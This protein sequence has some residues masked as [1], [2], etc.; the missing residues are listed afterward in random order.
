M[1]ITDADKTTKR[2]YRWRTVTEAGIVK[3]FAID[4][5]DGSALLIH[6]AGGTSFD[7][8]VKHMTELVDAANNYKRLREVERVLIEAD[9]KRRSTN[10][11]HSKSMHKANGFDVAMALIRANRE[12]SR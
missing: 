10:V 12:E 6:Q 2:K 3:Y 1:P 9:L 5:P 7:E 8:A 11:W 4:N